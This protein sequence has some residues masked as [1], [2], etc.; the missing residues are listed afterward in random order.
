MNHE[1]QDQPLVN[2]QKID[3]DETLT[4]TVYSK[5]IQGCFFYIIIMEVLLYIISGRLPSGSGDQVPAM[6]PV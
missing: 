1:R 4:E 5:W 6:T 2:K 3:K